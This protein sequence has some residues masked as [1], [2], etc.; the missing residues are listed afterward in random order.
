MFTPLCPGFARVQQLI[1]KHLTLKGSQTEEILRI[2]MVKV[3]RHK[4]EEGVS[5]AEHSIQT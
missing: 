2:Y 5:L 3:S 4:E 1:W